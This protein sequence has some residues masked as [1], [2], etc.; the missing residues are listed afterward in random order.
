MKRYILAG[1]LALAPLTISPSAHAMADTSHP[2][3]IGLQGNLAFPSD[4]D[5]S[6]AT[7]GTVAY[8]TSSGIGAVVGWRPESMNTDT[9]DVRAELEA[10]YHAFGLD[11]VRTNTNP[12]GDLKATT[13]MA[14]AYYDFNLDSPIK[15]Y[16][17]AGVGQGFIKFPT[18]KGLTNTD[19]KDNVFAY[20]AMVGVSYTPESLP[21]TDWS[22][23]YKYLGFE[24][25]KFSTASAA[26][27]KVSPL[28]ESAIELGFRYNF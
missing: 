6:G 19:S 27:V 17:G 26:D 20:Q 12:G 25:P 16:I 18:G 2:F 7:T 21:C 28:H 13:L 14:N 9:G 3:Y 22:L 5:V 8:G 10:S 1:L 4:S 24:A 11:R 15:P 23:G